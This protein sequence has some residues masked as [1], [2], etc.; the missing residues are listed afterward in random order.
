M[1]SILPVDAAIVE[2]AGH[3]DAVQ[4]A[5][6]A[7]GPFALDLLR[8]DLADHDA[9]VQGDAGVIERFVDRLV[10]VVVLDVLADDA[11]RHLVGR[12]LDRAA[13]CCASRRCRAA[14]PCRLQLLDD[15]LVELVLDQADRHLVDAELLVALLDDRPRLDVAEQGD[16][17]GVLLGQLAFGAADEDVGLDTDLPQP[18]DASA[19]SAWS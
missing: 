9:R 8:L 14:W 13:A 10:G 16:L 15:Q 5:Q 2:A 12:V 7:L 1:A 19:A 18:L 11:D 3:Q 6:H 17:L 4:A